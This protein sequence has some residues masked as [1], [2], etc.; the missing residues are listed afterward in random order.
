MVTI[1]TDIGTIQT[2]LEVARKFLANKQE[3]E[4][5]IDGSWD[6]V[7]YED[8]GNTVA[9]RQK[10]LDKDGNNITVFAGSPTRRGTPT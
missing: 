2:N 6:L 7:I 10:I 1:T 4:E 5:Q 8:D 9:W 3:M